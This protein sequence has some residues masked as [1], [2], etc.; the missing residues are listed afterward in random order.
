MKTVKFYLDTEFIDVPFATQLIS[1]GIVSE[2]GS[3]YYAV[4]SEFNEAL[5]N[6]WVKQNIFPFLL[7]PKQRKS[8]AEIKQEIITFYRRELLNMEAVSGEFWAYFGAYDWTL[9]CWLMGGMLTMDPLLPHVCYE[10]KQEVDRLG[11]SLDNYPPNEL[12]H[13]ALHDAAW[14]RK[15]HQRM[16]SYELRKCK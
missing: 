2:S 14:N 9:F 11:F 8:L 6:D 5:A 4:S 7:P 10:L 13:H 15:L 16:L 3:K 1:I 12:K